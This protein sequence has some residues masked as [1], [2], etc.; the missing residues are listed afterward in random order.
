MTPLTHAVHSLYHS[1]ISKS[2][3]LFI[4]RSAGC[5]KLQ[6]LDY[7]DPRQEGGQAGNPTSPVEKA[8]TFLL[9]FSMGLGW[10]W[11]GLMRHQLV[12][13]AQFDAH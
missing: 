7:V 11:A 3:C 10:D 12:Y 6:E 1:F 8:N 2:L 4:I 9:P 13:G 5:A